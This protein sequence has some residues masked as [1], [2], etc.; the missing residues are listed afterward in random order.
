MEFAPLQRLIIIR[1]VAAEKGKLLTAAALRTQLFHL[2]FYL[3]A[4]TLPVVKFPYRP[5]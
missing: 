4:L 5:R 1:I 3:G 2:S